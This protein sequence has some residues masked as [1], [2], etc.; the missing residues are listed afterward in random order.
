MCQKRNSVNIIINKKKVRVD[1]C[2]RGLIRSLNVHGIQTLACCCGHGKYP[3][4][5]VYRYTKLDPLRGN[6]YDFCSGW[7]IPRKKR[8]YKKDKEGYFYIPEVEANG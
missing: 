4:T 7:G 8:I 6:I 2:M 1:A 5:I 3:M